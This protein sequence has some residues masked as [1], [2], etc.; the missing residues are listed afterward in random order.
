MLRPRTRWRALRD[1]RPLDVAPGLPGWPADFAAWSQR[2]GGRGGGYPDVW[3]ARTDLPIDAPAR[4]GV[5]L[6]AYYADLLP[7]LFA[8]LR[9]LP[10]PYDLLITNATGQPIETPAD[11]GCLANVRTFEIANH[12][13]DILPLVSLVNAGHL[14]PYLLVLKIHT[15]RSQWR[16]AHDLDGDGARWRDDLLDALLGNEADVAAVL[17]SFAERPD[18]GIVTADGSVLGPEQWGDNQSL[19]ANLLRRL[20]LILVPDELRFAA[21]SMYWIRGFALQGLRALNLS[22]MDFEPEAGQVNQTTA[23]AIERLIGV[24]VAEAG[25]TIH[26][27]SSVPAPR[28]TQSW[29]RFGQA[30]LHP[31]ARVVPFY[32]PQF[33]PVPE[34]DR[35]WGKG[36][37]EW[38]N[39]SSAQPVYEG[40]YQP[41]LPTDL[42][43]YDLRLD[44]VRTAQQELAREAGLA[45][46]MYYHYWFAGRRLLDAPVWKLHASD[47]PQ[48]FCL[49]WANENWTRRWDGREA[50]VLIA[51]DYEHVSAEELIDDI[52]P[53]L[54][55]RRYMTI[56]GR[57]ILA[58]YR[59]GQV[60]D[61][62]ATV[63]GWR[64]RARRAGVGELYVLN[65][66]VVVEYDGLPDDPEA[67]GLDGS[68][69]FPPHNHHWQWLPHKGLGVDDR[70]TGN[71]LSYT[72]MAREAE[73]R[74]R[75]GSRS[76]FHPGV[77]VAFDNT[78]RRQWDSDV[79]YGSNAYTYRRWL[80]TA[81]RSVVDRDPDERLVFVNAWNEWAEGAILE[82]TDRHGRSFLLATRDVT[83]G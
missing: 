79:W 71:I 1:R 2:V 15:K 53:L 21:G 39:V 29:R 11:M 76:S 8:R 82:P 81:V 12:G 55:D 46:F 28:S 40:H 32:L 16:S 67:L 13:R 77:M 3:R 64:D 10:V 80:A 49:M 65:V 58:V 27:R 43:F 31:R 42:G 25:M 56:G 70:F 9:L 37:T 38:T 61:L 19:T 54:S 68:L 35:W 5:V 26:E 33:H 24:V 51:Q 72:A 20:E 47:V 17:S 48:P 22:A 6:H 36:F 74:H 50:D 63:A 62:A 45:G 30:E 66:D 7:E 75:A 18:L 52:L 73:R 69:G 23:H 44:E 34:N 78:P 59:A 4:V 41:R 57:K 14:D 83:L 60:P